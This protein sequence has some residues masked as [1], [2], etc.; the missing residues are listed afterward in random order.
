M[1]APTTKQPTKPASP[2]ITPDEFDY[3]LRQAQMMRAEHM[4]GIIDGWF[5][6]LRRMLQRERPAA[7][8][9]PGSVSRPA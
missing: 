2:E 5:S 9:A 7:P 4:A 6:G 8:V 3:Y 1:T